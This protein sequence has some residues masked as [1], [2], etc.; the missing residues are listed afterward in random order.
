MGVTRREFLVISGVLGAGV[1]LSSLGLDLGP[2]KAYADAA[3]D[4]Q[5]ENSEAHHVGLRLLLCRV[6]PD[7]EH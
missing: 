5:D 7:R 1:A 6:R 3:K 4:G 2:T